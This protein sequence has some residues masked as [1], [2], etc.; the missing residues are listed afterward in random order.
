[1]RRE[2][3]LAVSLTVLSLLTLTGMVGFH[4]IEGASLGDS[5]YMTVLTI[6]TVGFSEVFPLSTGGRVMT[7]VLIVTGV[8][9][10]LYTAAT[11]LEIGLERFMGGDARRKRMSR[12]IDQLEG[13]VIVC[14]FG[15]VGRNTWQALREEDVPVVVVESDPEAV[16][17]GIEAGVLI[18]EGDATRNEALAAAGIERARAL[19]ACVRNDNDNLVIVLSAKHQRGDLP[20]IA[21]ATEL[22]AQ[23]KLRLAGADRIVSPQLVGAHRL[24]AL[25]AQP[26]LDEFVDL[27]LHGRLVEF[28]IEEMKVPQGSVIAGKTLRESLIREQSGALVLGVESPGGELHLNPDPDLRIRGGAMIIAIGSAEQ[29]DRLRTYVGV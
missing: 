5:L 19:I 6:S 2:R 27:I 9:T 20:V 3:R 4:L 18:V 10:A 12:E 22:E 7:S 25:A 21:R 16:A 29:V 13:H 11:A 26:R 8:G 28:R 24:A 23:E 15:R 14:G 17:A 1:M